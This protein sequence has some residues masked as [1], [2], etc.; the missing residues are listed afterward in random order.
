[1][2]LD[3][4]KTIIQARLKIHLIF[5]KNQM[6]LQNKI[7]EFNLNI[8]ITQINYFSSKLPKV[9]LTAI[10]SIIRGYLKRKNST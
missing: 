5:Q 8:K 1:M 7:S 9:V 10:G 3:C 4:V 2:Y 6:H